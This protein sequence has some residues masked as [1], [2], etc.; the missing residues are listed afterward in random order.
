MSNILIHLSANF[1]A[2]KKAA[3]LFVLLANGMCIYAQQWKS[4]LNDAFREASASGK[5]VLLFFSVPEHC[6]SCDKL[7]T[8][9]LRSDE[10]LDYAK[11]NY[12]LV[13][14][15][16]QSGNLENMEENLLIVEKYN[17]DGFFPLVVIISKNAKILGQIGAYNDETPAQY[18]AR[19]Q[20]IKRS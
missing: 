14:Q 16:F 9:V 17:K 5:N 6:Y 13:K 10:F 20:S 12:V 2:M 7:D 4:N 18:V 3:I 15:D 8:N 1:N 19:L 11:S